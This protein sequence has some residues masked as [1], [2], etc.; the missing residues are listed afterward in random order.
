MG[1]IYFG[2]P[3]SRECIANVKRI[4]AKYE[5]EIIRNSKREDAPYLKW[6]TNWIIGVVDGTITRIAMQ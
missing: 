5:R 3:L 2:M 4:Y 1:D 6:E